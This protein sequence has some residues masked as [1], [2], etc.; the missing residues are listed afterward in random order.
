MN[1]RGVVATAA[2]VATAVIAAA[3]PAAAAAGAGGRLAVIA[4][5]QSGVTPIVR[6]IAGARRSIDMEIYELRDPGVLRAL[7]GAERRG[8][9]VR[10]LVNRHDPFESQSPNLS[11]Y[12]YLR[13]HDAQVRW[14]PS[15]LSLTHE[16]S[17]TVDGGVAAILTFNL[18]GEYSSTRD[19]GVIDRQPADVQ[20]IEQAFNA[21]WAGRHTSPSTGSG[22]LVWSP[23]AAPTVLRLIDSAERSI[24]V[25]SGEMHYPLATQALC[26]AAERGVDVKVVMSYSSEW[27]TA[28]H[29]LERC[30]AHVRTYYG[31]SYYIHAKVLITDGDRALVSSQNLSTE[32]LDYNRELGIMLT[33]RALIGRLDRWFESDYTHGRP[34]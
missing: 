3:G 10:V 11:A 9:D 4:E 14:A 22:D 13:S 6:L 18:A 7:A 2:A 23:G 15:Y 24:D 27:A 28:F 5:P 12:R 21:D 17:L 19:F 33:N 29:Q 16:K 1:H 20:A 30:G 25:E 32:S 34:D 8:V 31:Q 26:A